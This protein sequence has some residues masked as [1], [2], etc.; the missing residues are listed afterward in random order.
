MP[1]D[2]ITYSKFL[3]PGLFYAIP[4]MR[5]GCQKISG[6]LT[7]C[8]KSLPE[9]SPSLGPGYLKNRLQNVLESRAL[10]DFIGNPMALH[11]QKLWVHN[12]F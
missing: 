2:G 12:G 9:K 5:P 7:N 11:I 6:S 4:G 8:R 10:A 1:S 3:P